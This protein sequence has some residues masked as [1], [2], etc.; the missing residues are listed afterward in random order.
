MVHRW[1]NLD[2]SGAEG[3]RLAEARAQPGKGQSQGNRPQGVGGDRPKA[4]HRYV[5]L[6]TGQI[7]PA[8]VDRGQVAQQGMASER[9]V[10]PS[11]HRVG[12]A[13]ACGAQHRAVDRAGLPVQPGIADR[14]GGRH[15]LFGLV[16]HLVAA[17]QAQADQREAA[18]QVAPSVT[19]AMEAAAGPSQLGHRR[20]TLPSL[21]QQQPQAGLGARHQA[22]VACGLGHALGHLRVAAS[23]IELA[24]VV[25]GG[26]DTQL[27][28]GLEQLLPR[29][30]EGGGGLDELVHRRV[31]V[32]LLQ[33]AARQ[34]E[35]REPDEVAAG[36]LPMHCQ[37]GLEAGT[38]WLKLP[39]GQQH[40]TEGGSHR[41]CPLG[42]AGLGQDQG[43]LAVASGR[44]QVAGAEGRGDVPGELAGLLRQIEVVGGVVHL[45]GLYRR[46]RPRGALQA[47]SPEDRR[48]RYG[49]NLARASTV[50]SLPGIVAGRW[51]SVLMSLAPASLAQFRILVA[52]AQADGQFTSEEEEVLKGALGKHADIL[53]DLLGEDIDVD[54]EIALLDDE[55]KRAVYQSAFA[56]AY[57][58]G[59]AQTFEVAILKKLMPNKGEESLLGQ[60]MGETLD[61]VLPGR[62]V[63]EPDPAKRDSEVL[64]DTLKYSALAAV[65][66]AMPVPGVAVVADIAV[67]AIQ[68]KLVHDIGMYWGHS[69]D[70][71]AVRGFLGAAAGSIGLRI[72]VN[73]VARFVPGWGSAFAAATS[74]ATT[75]AM[76]RAANAWF[77]AGRD[78]TDQELSDIFKTATTQ[79]RAEFSTRGDDVAAARTAHADKLA[80]LN[81]Q[82]AAGEIDRA[83]FEAQVAS[84]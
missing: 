11:Q 38:G 29:S 4:A 9:S 62:I 69:L 36:A 70:Q 27:G 25:V 54:A 19:Q 71:K 79:G 52:V 74:F 15:Q 28:G 55:Q 30:G 8:L 82:L 2:P 40:P 49:R 58:D 3:L 76:G 12:E 26:G 60:V 65:A 35:E 13:V 45:W 50:G 1:G 39:L 75:Y 51:R 47:G 6:A 83:T 46:R 73:N 53:D 33:V 18:A 7:E 42:P 59:H 14:L 66:G 10:G 61:T 43:L 48:R 77:A 22:L 34:L 31:G 84:L 67:V 16:V 5:A 21:V 24:G 63:A 17:L 57:A 81:R 80:E 72:A 32:A 20:P 78:M 68:G 37:G 41:G 56:L 44:C 64:E 23:G